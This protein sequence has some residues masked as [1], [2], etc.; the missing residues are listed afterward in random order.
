[1]NKRSVK[2]LDGR[3]YPREL[4]LEKKYTIKLDGAEIMSVLLRLECG[5]LVAY[6]D[7]EK[8]SYSKMLAK[9]IR[10]QVK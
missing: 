2:Y 9:Q 8:N 10:K 6:E 3:F 5:E 1:M 7:S 4:D